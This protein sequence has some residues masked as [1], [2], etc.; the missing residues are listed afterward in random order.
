MFVVRQTIAPN[1]MER[2]AYV[3]V[4]VEFVVSVENGVVTAVVGVVSQNEIVKVP[5]THLGACRQCLRHSG[6]NGIY[7]VRPL[8]LL[9]HYVIYP[10]NVGDVGESVQ[11]RVYPHYA[12]YP[13]NSTNFLW[14]GGICP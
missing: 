11:I 3:F 6:L 10:A 4:I 9:L 5:R 7:M 1:N 8:S 12:N 14:G 2:S 13:G